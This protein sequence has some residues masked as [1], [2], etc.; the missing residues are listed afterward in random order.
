MDDAEDYVIG[1]KRDRRTG[2]PA[3]WKDIVR[4]MSGVVV[5]GEA[6]AA[7]LQ[8]HASSDAIA[9]V[10]ERLADYVYI[11]KVIRHHPSQP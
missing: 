11:E 1:V 6:N 3:D 9:R 8:V 7:R 10:R 2:V 4:G 5:R